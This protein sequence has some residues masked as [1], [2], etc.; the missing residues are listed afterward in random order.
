[1]G[2]ADTFDQTKGDKK[3]KKKKKNKK[4]KEFREEKK[5]NDQAPM[6]AEEPVDV[7]MQSVAPE[8]SQP[9]AAGLEDT[10]V[11]VHIQPASDGMDEQP[12]KKRKR[13]HKQKEDSDKE[14]PEFEGTSNTTVDGAA[15]T[16]A[17]PSE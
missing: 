9:A 11:P 2:D 8:Q 14:V 16:H 15:T 12:K 3:K 7:N 6:P 17:P 5:G 4:H 10:V 1:M 13:K